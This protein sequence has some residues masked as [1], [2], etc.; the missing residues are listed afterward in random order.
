MNLLDLPEEILYIIATMCVNMS[1]F[2]IEGSRIS[3]AFPS[4]FPL[5]CRRLNLLFSDVIQI[6]RTLDFNC[7]RRFLDYLL[8]NPILAPF[9]VPSK[10]MAVDL[11]YNTFSFR[12]SR[13]LTLETRYREYIRVLVA[14]NLYS[15]ILFSKII[16]S[17][18]YIIYHIF[19]LMDNGS[20]FL[21]LIIDEHIRKNPIYALRCVEYCVRSF[22]ILGSRAHAGTII[23]YLNGI[24]T[25]KKP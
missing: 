10:E 21:N 19:S 16:P 25:L 6:P 11:A 9:M 18:T 8:D 13:Q 15:S 12:P 23:M 22:N 4:G 20:F 1:T 14:P 3:C 5:V 17:I 2:E 7:Q 24:T